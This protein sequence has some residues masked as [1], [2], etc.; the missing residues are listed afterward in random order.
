MLVEQYLSLQIPSFGL[1]PFRSC[2]FIVFL[3]FFL[4]RIL[5]TLHFFRMTGG[6]PVIE[7]IT[8]SCVK[9]WIVGGSLLLVA[10]CSPLNVLIYLTN[11]I[12]QQLIYFYLLYVLPMKKNARYPLYIGFVPTLY[13]ST[14]PSN[15]IQEQWPGK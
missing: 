10:C 9:T 6:I 12:C 11:I 4:F 15:G 3:I 1:G 7:L 2:H 8:I 5:F 14:N 13:I